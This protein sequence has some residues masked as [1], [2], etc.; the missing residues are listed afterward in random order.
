MR[1]TPALLIVFAFAAGTLM[2]Q[3]AGV[4]ALFGASDPSDD[5]TSGEEFAE[6]GED[7]ILEDQEG[8]DNEEFQPDTRGSDNLVG[9]IISAFGIVFNY[10][11]LVVLFPIELQNIGL[12]RWAAYPIGLITQTI[13]V[14]GV[15]MFA[16]GRVWT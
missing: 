2:F 5:L 14:F 8:E 12:P 9:F 6:E 11:Q 15:A 4:G 1:T 10:V 13:A 3:L 16:S 7:N